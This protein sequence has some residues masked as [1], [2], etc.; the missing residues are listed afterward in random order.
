MRKK[1]WV[2]IVAILMMTILIETIFIVTYIYKEQEPIKKALEE[3]G[4]SVYQTRYTLEN[5]YAIPCMRV[6]IRNNQKLE[7]K[8]NKS[9]TKYFS[10]L[11]EPFIG[12]S[13]TEALPPIIHLQS[14]R[15]LSVEYSFKYLKTYI[16]DDN[17]YWHLCVTVDMQSGEVIFLDD[18]IDINDSFA[19][20]IKHGRIL[21]LE[22]NSCIT[23]QEIMDKTVE[24]LTDNMNDRFS[25]WDLDYIKILFR[26]YAKEYLYGEYYRANGY[27]M[28]DINP[29]LYSNY[30]YLEEENICFS[31]FEGLSIKKIRYDDLS[32]YLKVLR[33]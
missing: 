6:Y 18:L 12:E 4:Y 26:D 32:G 22:G 14:S 19:E 20:L 17:R 16:N 1:V 5:G 27:D 28:F 25:K 23:A 11:E 13:V 9:L 10:I 24:E 15:Y 3:P 8:V 33:P 7:D 29:H 30:F 21:R 31:G 2:M